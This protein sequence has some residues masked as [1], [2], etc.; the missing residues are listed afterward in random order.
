MKDV[1]DELAAARR[2]MGTATLPAG[3]A[4]TM[5][6]RRRYDAPVD[7]VWNA[8]TDP[9]RLGLGVSTTVFFALCGLLLL[10]AAWGLY[11]VRPWARGPVLLTQ[12]ISLALAWTQREDV[13]VATVLVAVAVVVLAGLLHP[14][15]IEALEQARD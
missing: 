14:R 8:I 10:A 15:S 3:D 5:E 12:L 6:L 9:E 11:R 1:L 7:D 2:T 4:Y 13:V